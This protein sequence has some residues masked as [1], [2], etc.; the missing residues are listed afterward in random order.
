MA[1]RLHGHLAVILASGMFMADP[2]LLPKAEWS[3]VLHLLEQVPPLADTIT[4]A[5]RLNAMLRRKTSE[6]LSAVLDAADRTPLKEFAAGLRRDIGAVQAALDN[7]DAGSFNGARAQTQVDK[8]AKRLLQAHR[9]RG[10][11]AGDQHI[12][13]N[14]NAQ[15]TH[16]CTR[17]MRI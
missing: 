3:L 4:V 12:G 15:S 9:V 8:T 14:S 16:Y 5:K 7:A 6:S 2:E 11:Q 13:R 10:G 1:V 17:S